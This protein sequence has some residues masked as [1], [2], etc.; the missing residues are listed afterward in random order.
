VHGF[1]RLFIY[2]LTVEIEVTRRENWDLISRFNPATCLWMF[3]PKRAFPTSYVVAFLHWASSVKMRD[4][5]SFC[6]YWVIND[7]FFKTR[8]RISVIPLMG[9]ALR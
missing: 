4:D 7:V 5:C 6:K 2:T 9:E 3:Q 1:H 8:G